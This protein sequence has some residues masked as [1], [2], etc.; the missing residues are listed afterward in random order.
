MNFRRQRKE[1]RYQDE[2]PLEVKQGMGC[3]RNFSTSG[4]YFVTDQ[5]LTIGEQLEV[6][7][8]NIP[9]RDLGTGSATRVK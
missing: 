5:G 6:I 8:S 3:T 9:D 1:M 4:L 2:I 7:C